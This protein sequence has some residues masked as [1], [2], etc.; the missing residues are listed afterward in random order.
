MFSTLSSKFKYRV[1]LF[2]MYLF[3]KCFFLDLIKEQ[4]SIKMAQINVQ[5]SFISPIHRRKEMIHILCEE[6]KNCGFS[7]SFS[8]S[9]R[10]IC[11]LRPD[12]CG[13][14]RHFLSLVGNAGQLE[15]FPF[16]TEFIFIVSKKHSGWTYSIRELGPVFTGGPASM[17]S[18]DGS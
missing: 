5:L 3:L 8:I 14:E 12:K 18:C 9:R 16:T 2:L 7:C 11:L 10:V 15:I 6:I 1:K 4:Y 13:T 17:L